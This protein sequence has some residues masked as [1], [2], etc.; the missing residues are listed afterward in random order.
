MKNNLKI[1]MLLCVVIM[2]CKKEETTTTT[3]TA[4]KT[5]ENLTFNLK[6]AYFSTD[7]SMTVPVDSNK[8]KSIASKIDITFIYNY[9][10][11]QPGF[12]D[13]KARSQN[14][15]WDGY[16]N[17]WLSTAVETMYYSTKLTKVQFDEAKVAEGKIATYFSDASV[18]LVP[19]HIFPKG[20]CIGGR[21]ATNL[22]IPLKEG[23]V[24]GFKNKASGKR[25]L[26]YI[27]TDQVDFWPMYIISSNTK[28]DIIREN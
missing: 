16:Y 11:D 8:A 2:S 9:D 3:T 19:H 21:Q 24:F 15:Y 6:N 14:W 12:F 26:L 22:T 27:R 18:A 5:Y 17:P 1:L 13:P 28:V 7:G 20:S 25:G 10:Y 23:S 4:A